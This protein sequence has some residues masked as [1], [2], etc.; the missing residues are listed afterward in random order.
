LYRPLCAV[1]ADACRIVDR[2]AEVAD[3]ILCRLG[4]AG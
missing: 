1:L 2:V 4:A 3:E